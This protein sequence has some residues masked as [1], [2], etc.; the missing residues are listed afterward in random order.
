MG[1]DS[2]VFRLVDERASSVMFARDSARDDFFVG[3]EVD[4][5]FERTPSVE[6]M[7]R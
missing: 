2:V 1:R 6:S 7:Q 5:R 3:R 4:R